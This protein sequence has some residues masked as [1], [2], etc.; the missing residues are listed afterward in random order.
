MNRSRQYK[1]D[2]EL[3][4]KLRTKKMSDNQTVKDFFF[5]MSLNIIT[6]YFI[7]S[8]SR[9][10]YN[11]IYEVTEGTSFDGSTI[12]GVNVYEFDGEEYTMSDKRKMCYS[13]EE[14][15]SYLKALK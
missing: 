12:Y 6:P 1:L 2:K 5:S 3:N 4:K 11:L 10:N 13:K 14:L 7:S 8:G 15:D 9:N